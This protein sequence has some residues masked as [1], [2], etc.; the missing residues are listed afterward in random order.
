LGAGRGANNPTPDKFTVTKA[1]RRPRHIQGCSANKEEDIM[2]CSSVP[3]FLMQAFIKITIGL[4]FLKL[5]IQGQNKGAAS[6]CL[7][8]TED[9]NSKKPVI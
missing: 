2:R 9:N 8:N 6:I 3:E 5:K 1:W 4:P 7:Q